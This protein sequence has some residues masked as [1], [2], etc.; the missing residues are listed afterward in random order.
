MKLEKPPF[1]SLSSFLFWTLFVSTHKHDNHACLEGIDHC[2]KFRILNFRPSAHFPDSAQ[3]RPAGDPTWSKFPSS[4]RL[5]AILLVHDHPLP[6]TSDT[7]RIKRMSKII[8]SL[9]VSLCFSVSLQLTCKLETFS[10]NM[11]TTTTRWS[12]H[13]GAWPP[14]Q[15]RWNRPFRLSL[16]IA[17][18]VGGSFNTNWWGQARTGIKVVCWQR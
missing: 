11:A 4:L 18:L 6:A 1:S 10:N 13:C 7:F 14:T 5:G 3:P 16:Q 15:N 9:C 2:R 17:R 8:N 12:C